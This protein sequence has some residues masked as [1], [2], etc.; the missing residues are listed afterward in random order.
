MSC[1]F[2]NG[3]FNNGCLLILA[4]D[5]TGAFDTGVQFSRYGASVQVL[6]C[7]SL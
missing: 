6:T 5:L 7:G 4:E 1:V 2:K 3:T